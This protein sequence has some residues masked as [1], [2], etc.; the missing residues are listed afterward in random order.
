MP[1]TCLLEH[2]IS[3]ER[4]VRLGASYHPTASPRR[5]RRGASHGTH[6]RT[7]GLEVRA[8]RS[9]ACGGADPGAAVGG[10]GAVVAGRSGGGS[11][12]EQGEREH[13][14]AAAGAVGRGGAGGGTGGPAG[15]L[16]RPRGAA[17]PHPG[18]AAAAAR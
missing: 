2:S 16:L 1:T 17:Q 10:R 5:V 4:T 18:G 12:D 6:R 14:R 13:E 11:G 9:A 8:G 3:S 7:D 15:L